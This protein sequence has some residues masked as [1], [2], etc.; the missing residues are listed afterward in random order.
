VRDERDDAP[1]WDS[2]DAAFAE[3]YPGVDPQHVAPA[4]PTALGG[5]LDGISAFGTGEQ[6]H[7]VTYG[8]TELF[9]KES[10]DLELSGWGYELTLLT[11][12]AE[13]PPAW[14]IELLLAVAR[15]TMEQGTWFD[16]GHR[17]DTG[18]DITGAS[19]QLT[20]VAFCPDR[21]VQP[22]SFPFGRYQFL[23]MVGVTSSELAEMKAS[24]TAS[25][26]ERLASR[27]PLLRTSTDAR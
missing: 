23:Q 9:E 4:T 7:F 15:L 17:L 27:D 22:S 8:L 25:V 26:L 11:P 2:I 18:T 19:G 20:A 14:A 1:G 16:T 5:V 12:A 10:E 24:S 6:W 21:L 3:V 13:Q